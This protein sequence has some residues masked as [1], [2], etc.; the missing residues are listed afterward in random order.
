MAAAAT[1]MVVLVGACT[2]AAG[3]SSGDGELPSIV[4]LG[5]TWESLYAQLTVAMVL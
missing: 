5:C 4:C 1:S 2:A 3:G